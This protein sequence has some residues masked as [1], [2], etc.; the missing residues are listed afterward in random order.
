VTAPRDDDRTAWI[1]RAT[2]PPPRDPWPTAEQPTVAPVPPPVVYVQ[3]PPRRHWRLVVALLLL[4]FAAGAAVAVTTSS[5]LRDA[6]GLGPDP[7]TTPAPSPSP[8]PSPTP[9]TPP[10]PGIGDPVRDGTFEFRVV[11]VSCGHESVQ[12]GLLRESAD[13]Q[14]C[15]VGIAVTNTGELP[16]LF[17]DRAQHLIASDGSRHR[18]DTTAGV[19]ANEGISVWASLV[20]PGRTAAG[21]LVFDIPSGTT[22]AVVELHDS[23]FSDGTLVT[24]GPVTSP[25]AEETED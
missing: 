7:T 16:A 1:G 20:L 25:S 15:L 21:T 3:A 23:L 2:P 5:A 18:A 14:Y 12:W 8:T 6:I 10:P 4:S 9:T 11:E 24:I 22:A 17:I 13:G 19:I